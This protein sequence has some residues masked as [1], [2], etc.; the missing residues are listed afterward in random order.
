VS[1]DDRDLIAASCR[2]EVESRSDPAAEQEE[3]E[4]GER[5]EE[6]IYCA[7]LSVKVSSVKDGGA[8]GV[9]RIDEDVEEEACRVW[10]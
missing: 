3:E 10:K 4:S 1:E 2:E 9:S 5:E 7:A 6:D 8:F